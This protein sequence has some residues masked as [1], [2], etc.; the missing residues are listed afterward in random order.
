MS[1]RELYENYTR[2]ELI[3]ALTHRDEVIAK[4]EDWMDGV[5]AGG[6][7]GAKISSQADTQ[8]ACDRVVVAVTKAILFED[9]GSTEDWQEN[10]EL[11]RAAVTAYREATGAKDEPHECKFMWFGDQPK[12]RC[13]HCAVVEG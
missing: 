7:S 1:A 8:K 5:G 2:E 13:V 3:D 6:V 11:G 12:R 10:M 9:C 4:Y